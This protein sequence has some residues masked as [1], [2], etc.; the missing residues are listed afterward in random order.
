MIV[1]IAV[2]GLAGILIG[3]IIMVV[4]KEILSLYGIDNK[5]RTFFGDILNRF[6][7]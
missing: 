1:G 6:S 7:A 3:P 5:L 4:A 2:Y